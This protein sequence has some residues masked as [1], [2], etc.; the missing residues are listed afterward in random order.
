MTTMLRRHPAP[1]H[2][3][4]PPCNTW[5]EGAAVDKLP[6][7]MNTHTTLTSFQGQSY[8]G[9]HAST[10]PYPQTDKQSGSA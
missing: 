10:A 1:F 8:H 6:D 7:A 9:I 4:E 3:K 2:H 5:L